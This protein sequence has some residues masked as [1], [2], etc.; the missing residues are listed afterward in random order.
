MSDLSFDGRV[1]GTEGR[2]SRA[3]PRQNT[4][5]SPQVGV[6]VV[7]LAHTVGWSRLALNSP[8]HGHMGGLA[9]RADFS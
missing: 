2:R 7:A 4:K 8:I 1:R 3:V 5:A 6:L 9:M